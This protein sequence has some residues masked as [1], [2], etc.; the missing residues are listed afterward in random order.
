MKSPKWNRREIVGAAGAV[1][2]AASVAPR[3]AAAASSKSAR[4]WDIIG[5]GA[6][7]S[8]M[9]LAIFAAQRGARVLLLDINDKM[10]GTLHVSTGQMAAAGTRLQKSKGITDTPQEHY[11]DLQRITRGTIDPVL[12]RKTAW[13]AAATFDWLMDQGLEVLPTMP[14][15]GEAH[16]PYSKPRYYW[17]PDGGRSILKVLGKVLDPLIAAGKVQ[18]LLRH[19]VTDLVQDSRGAVTGVQARDSDGRAQ[20]FFGRSIVLTTGGYCANPSLYAR[21]SNRPQYIRM[22][23]ERSLGRG[24]ELAQAAGGWLRGADN[25]MANFGLV[26]A[27]DNY[28]AP[29]FARPI[30]HPQRRQ[31]WEIYVNAQG[32]RFVR[33]DIPSVDAREQSLLRQTGNRRWIVYDSAISAAAPPVLTG[34]TRDKIMEQFGAHP[35]FHRADDLAALAESAGISPAGLANSVELYNYGIRTGNDLLGRVHK[36]L[37]I[38]KPP[39][40]AIRAQGTSITGAVGIGVDEALR[41]TR[42]N[43]TP[44]ANLYACGE[45]LGAGQTQGKAYTG[46]MMV[47]PALTF[48]RLLGQRGGLPG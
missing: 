4:Q 2:V 42:G 44:I 5:V 13:N 16:E 15:D 35:W 48:A 40:F 27:S 12:A 41:V 25:Y 8:G 32:E 11:D 47:T 22:A 46:G 1:A 38:L 20:S 7:T 36:P 14:V 30:D 43:G 17:G 29:L 19:D 45:V 31:P 33:E 24:L 23:Y 37:P 9:M 18:V 34:F 10:G 28:P 6:G 26:L 39:F 3:A 21:L